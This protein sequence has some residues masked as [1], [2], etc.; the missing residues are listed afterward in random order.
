MEGMEELCAEKTVNRI[1]LRPQ[2]GSAAAEAKKHFWDDASR[3]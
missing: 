2:E 1:L 3:N